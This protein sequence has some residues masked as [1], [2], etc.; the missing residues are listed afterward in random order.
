[1]LLF[2][3]ECTTTVVSPGFNRS[4]LPGSWG[5]EADLTQVLSLGMVI[6]M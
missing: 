4:L 5:D 2:M 1:M 3:Q 6:I